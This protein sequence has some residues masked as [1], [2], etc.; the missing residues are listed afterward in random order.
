MK[1]RS[2]MTLSLAM[3]ALG[4]DSEPAR[5]KTPGKNQN[6]ADSGGLGLSMEIKTAEAQKEELLSQKSENEE[7]LNALRLGNNRL[8]ERLFTHRKECPVAAR[9]RS[10]D[11]EKVLGCVGNYED[12]ARLVPKFFVRLKS[13]SSGSFFLRADNAY[14]S[15]SFTS[16]GSLMEVKWN[17]INSSDTKTPRIWDLAQLKFK[18]APGASISKNDISEFEF[19]VNDKLI[20]DQADLVAI[21]DSTATLDISLGRLL[22]WKNDSVKTESPC[23]IADEEI[24]SIISGAKTDASTGSAF[25]LEEKKADTHNADDVRKLDALKTEITNIKK[26]LGEFVLNIER[27]SDRSGKLTRELIGDRNVGCFARLPINTL[28]LEINGAHLPNKDVV[29]SEERRSDVNNPR[30]FTFT[31]GDQFAHV[32]PDEEQQSLIVSGG[33]LLSRKFTGKRIGDIE[34]IS[35]EKGGIGID[36]MENCW[37]TWFGTRCEW[38]NSEKNRYRLDSIAIKVNGEVL[39]RQDAVNFTFQE[40]KLLWSDKNLGVN[41]AFRAL[42]RRT[43]CPAK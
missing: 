33:H 18:A 4:C 2:F 21:S 31:F 13:T 30:Q 26:Q 36:S 40:G 9:L 1:T 22:I 41:Q 8:C 10:T 17:P 32:N 38:Q 12:G 23:M 15:T 43:D 37:K 42:M 6:G 29:I 5:I 35:I 28:E 20:I 11:N 27:E 24:D 14:D 34:Y 25:S 16:N 7:Q 39:Y 19:W 3:F